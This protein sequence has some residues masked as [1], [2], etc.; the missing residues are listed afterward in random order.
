MKKITK[1]GKG[2]ALGTA[3]LAASLLLIAPAALAGGKLE[4]VAAKV[5]KDPA[6]IDAKEWGKAKAT[7]ITL[8]GAGDFENKKKEITVKAVYTKK[9]KISMLLSWPDDTK[10]MDGQ[11]WV[12]EGDGW[13]QKAGYED[14]VA[15]N[16]EARRIKK[17]ANKG[18]AVLCH[19]DAKNPNE[20]KY[21]TEK[22]PQFG[23]LWVWESY[24]TD[25]LG[26]GGDN[27][28]DDDSRKADKG[29]GKPKKNINKYKTG[30]V[31]MQDPGQK[32]QLAGFLMDSQKAK[33]GDTDIGE[34]PTWMLSK[35]S[36]DYADIISK[37]SYS[38]GKWTVMLQRQ[39]DTKSDTDVKF[40]TKKKY[41]VG[42]AVFDNSG[43]HHSYNSPPAKVIFK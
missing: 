12:K 16:W 42:I 21:H 39:L 26:H 17:F 1:Y 7:K 23:D 27:F 22:A 38:G 5:K 3:A 20:W 11:A 31:Y 33:I 28:V 9:G 4:I 18:C 40:N 29:T 43:A 10:S 24:R 30:P 25:A 37:S 32:P 15:L 41:N 19:S 8:D 35:F 36:G 34:T 2:L 14:K 13:K 6:G